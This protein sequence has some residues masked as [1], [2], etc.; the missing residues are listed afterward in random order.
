MS[1]NTKIE[2]AHHTVNLWTGCTKVHSGCDNCYAESWAKRW[3]NN[4]W[5]NNPRNEV[6]GA[7]DLLARLQK[8]AQRDGEIQRV[9]INSLSDIFEKTMPLIDSKGKLIENIFT[10]NLRSQFFNQIDFGRYENLMFLLLTKRPSNINKI[11]PP[12]WIDNPPKNV[13]FGTSPCDQETA[14]ILIPQLLKVNGKK[15][16]SIEPQLGHINLTALNEFKNTEINCL[17]GDTTHS[18]SE[19]VGAISRGNKIDWVIQG[20]ESGHGKRPFNLDWAH[21]IREQCKNANIPYFFK[22]I[23]KVQDIPEEMLVREFPNI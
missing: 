6:K 13:I 9:F 23:D 2:W 14:D 21:S 17:T 10:G 20:G 3:G 12:Y 5:G 11:I 19:G 22:Q 16:L 4:I 8:N 18:T 1:E 7:W 15:F